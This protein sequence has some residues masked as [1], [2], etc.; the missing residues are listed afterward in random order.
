MEQKRI[1]ILN[2]KFDVNIF[3]QVFKRSIILSIIIFFAAIVGVYVYLRYT[4]PIY[5][6]S[7]IIQLKNEGTTANKVLNLTTAVE[8]I[9]SMQVIELIRSK[10]FL[11][12]TFNKL[13]L[14]IS[15]FSQ[16]TFLENELYKANP[17]SIDY[18][19]TK[20]NLYNVPI[21]VSF[22]KNGDSN[23]KYKTNN[24]NFE[25]TIKKN[26]WTDINGLE[27]KIEV[28]DI[29]AIRTQINKIKNDSYYFIINDTESVYKK[30]SSQ[31][32]VSLLNQEANTIQISFKD[33]NA[34][35]TSEIVNTIAEEF[36][37][38]D[39]E[40][41]KESSQQI[42]NFIEN[43]NNLIYQ[44]LDSIEGLLMQFGITHQIRNDNDSKETGTERYSILLSKIEEELNIPFTLKQLFS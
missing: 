18:K 22:D 15:Y 29:D 31:L 1:P 26:K 3:L 9:N 10:E 37:K 21:Y 11:K 4:L 39:L 6:S 19:N 5:K 27:I 28:T 44:Q 41:K 24:T 20:R 12:R 43:Q 30:Y 14:K 35:K 7:S 42:L 8:E 25:K 13:P 38:Y 32:E 23:I 17:F 2:E 34:Q 40:K 36:I 16:G 33:N